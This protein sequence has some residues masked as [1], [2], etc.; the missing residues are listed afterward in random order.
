[1]ALI[2]AAALPA[3]LRRINLRTFRFHIG[4]TPFHHPKFHDAAAQQF[5]PR[6]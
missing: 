3:R 1:M 6:S 4:E 5:F 2:E